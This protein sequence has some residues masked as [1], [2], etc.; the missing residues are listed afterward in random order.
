VIFKAVE[1]DVDDEIPA[2]FGFE[3]RKKNLLKLGEENQFKIENNSTAQGGSDTNMNSALNK[4]DNNDEDLI[5]K[6]L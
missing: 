2:P 6:E 5:D 1:L 3:K 4:T